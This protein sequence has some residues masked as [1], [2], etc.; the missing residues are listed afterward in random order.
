MSRMFRRL[1]LV[2]FASLPALA[3]AALLA[4]DVSTLAARQGVCVAAVVTIK[5]G[6]PGDAMVVRGCDT[7]PAVDANTVFQVASLSKPVFAYAVLKLV[8]QGRL[9]LDRPLAEYLPL[10]YVHAHNPFVEPA[11]SGSDLLTQEQ[12][13]SVTA[14]HVLSHSSGLP[15]WSGKALVFGFQPGT[16]WRYSGEAYVLLQRVL[17]TI[18]GQA[19]DEHLRQALFEPLAMHNSSFVWREPLRAW[20]VAGTSASGAAVRPDRFGRPLAAATL[21]STASDYARFVAALLQDESALRITLEQPVRVDQRL[22][23]HW[24]LGWG[25]AD[26]ESGRYLWHWGNNPGYRAFVMVSPASGDGMVLLTNSEQGLKLAEPL[27]NTVLPGVHPVLAFPMLGLKPA[28]FWCGTLV[29]R[30]TNTATNE[31]DASRSQGKAH[32]HSDTSWYR[33]DL[34]R[35]HGPRGAISCGR[36][37]EMGY[38]GWC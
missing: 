2:F 25:L 15:N 23:L 11:A 35:S 12:L 38:L 21:Y 19:L 18:T 31:I 22:G 17:E 20:A 13:L 7:A 36:I 37:C 5:A 14:R 3:V 29:P 1:T 16:A 10:G 9:N 4:Q 32:N 28:G 34:Q 27:L 6:V 26:D 30:F 33:E 24:A 8:Q